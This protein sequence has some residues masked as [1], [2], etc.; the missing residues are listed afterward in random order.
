ML[1]RFPAAVLVLF[2]V[3]EARVTPTDAACF[4]IVGAGLEVFE[5][6]DFK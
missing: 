2:S 5:L 6:G 1:G 4:W 3:L